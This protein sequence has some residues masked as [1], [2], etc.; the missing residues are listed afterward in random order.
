MRLTKGSIVSVEV[1]G[2]NNF[3]MVLLKLTNVKSSRSG[4]RDIRTVE[5]TDIIKVLVD[6]GYESFVISSAEEYGG[7][8]I[9]DDETEKVN[10]IVLND[11][12]VMDIES[13]VIKQ[14][15]KE[16]DEGEMLDFYIS[17]DFEKI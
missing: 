7:G 6:E 5:G 8:L 11:N 4:I 15:W 17:G 10:I 1:E 3:A 12:D 13:N 14:A 9:E 2:L 16:S